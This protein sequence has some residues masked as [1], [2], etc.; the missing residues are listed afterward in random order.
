MKKLSLILLLIIVLLGFILR[1]YKLGSV[2]SGF[3]RDEAFLG[4]NAYSI[5]KTGQDMSGHLLPLHLESFLYSPAGYSYF[6]I[7]FIYLFGL[8][9]FSVRFA[10]ALFGSLTIISTYFLTK[11][12]FQNFSFQQISGKELKDMNSNKKTAKQ[13]HF[14]SIEN[15]RLKMENIA[16]ISSAIIAINPWHIN[17]S[18]TATENVIVV[19]F[20]TIALYLFLVWVKSKKTIWLAV[21]FL[22]FLFT[23]FIYQ[24]PRSFLPVF[25][26]LFVITVLGMRVFQDRKIILLLLGT[27]FIFILIPVFIIL[28]S[29]NLSLRITTVS[30]FS[31]G[32]SQLKIDQFIR[33]DGVSGVS[34]GLSRM[35]HNKIATYTNQI[36]QNYFKH[37]SYD[38]LFTDNYYPDRYRIPSAGLLYPYELLLLIAGIWTLEK[39]NK[40]LFTLL[41]GWI[42]F[43]FVGSALTFD[44]VP[45]MQRTLIAIPAISII[46]AIGLVQLWK[47]VKSRKYFR[48]SFGLLFICF[49]VYFITVYLHQ[50]YLHYA[51]YR[52][53]YR[54]DG[55]K[56]LVA[57]TNIYLKDYRKAII[58]D[59]E[60]APTIFYLFFN[61]YDPALFQKETKNSEF[62]GFNRINFGIYEFTQT[63]CPLG[64]DSTTKKAIGEK[65]ILYV[66]S[67]LCEIPKDAKV[68]D[69]I[70]RS[71]NSEVFQILSKKE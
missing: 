67:S 14:L 54:H 29:G 33:E 64:I 8:S 46:S 63:E 58:T 40:R 12:L 51:V 70:K 65:S 55:Y 57:K 13:N 27:F 15:S 1:F 52:P 53:W 38:F 71:D 17:L 16:I 10:S 42:L 7:P 23:I 48:Y 59:R 66:N 68:H 45:N 37:F 25:I 2:P 43:A 20:T 60:S 28:S 34:P 18:R 35:F 44:D 69:I 21:S 19:F 5:L 31:T 47:L 41:A 49:I 24:A 36:V 30:I 26:P 4:Y 11:Q 3:H 6:S 22:S 50:Y 62:R 9:I 56:T 39:F 32:E 61:T